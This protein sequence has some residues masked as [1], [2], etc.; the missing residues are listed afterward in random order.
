VA[1]VRPYRGVDAADR[2][3]QRRRQ[4][5]EA[6]LDVLGSES[7]T[8]EL[9]VRT[10]CQRAGLT[11]RYFYESFTDKDD[12]VAAVFDW[13]LG[14]LAATTQAAVSSAPLKERNR[15]G[16]ANLIQTIAADARV[17]R[18]IIGSRA[19]AVLV[20]R[21]AETGALLAMLYGQNVTEALGVPQSERGK[22]TAHFALGGVVQVISTWLAGDI[23]I[24]IDG[25][26]DQ[27]ALILDDLVDPE[28]YRS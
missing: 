6:G 4:L 16:M 13:V 21:Q 17:G 5:L 27:L 22:A 1:Q 2:V 7:G 8:T 3:A 12:F 20:R 19:N 25:L 9:T 18:F 23:D 10:I 15:A 14:D 28:L 11:L 26:V 24:D